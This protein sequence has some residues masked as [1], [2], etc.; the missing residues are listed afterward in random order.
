M[1]AD[2]TNAARDLAASGTLFTPGHDAERIALLCDLFRDDGG[3][4]GDLLDA[5]ANLRADS[6]SRS[7][8]AMY[9]AR[10]AVEAA[11]RGE[12]S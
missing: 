9:R 3:P 12:S 10:D 5:I 8:A 6:E 1:S 2:R 7:Y 11:L 4:L